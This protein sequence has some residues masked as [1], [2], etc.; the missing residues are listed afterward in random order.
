LIKVFSLNRVTTDTEL[1]GITNIS[2]TYDDNDVVI[3]TLD[4]FP[5]LWLES[6][7]T[8]S[9]TCYK[10]DKT[11]VFSISVCAPKRHRSNKFISNV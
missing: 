8:D 10:L 1:D 5:L 4:A 9:D 7:E 6:V 2:D 3:D 11:T